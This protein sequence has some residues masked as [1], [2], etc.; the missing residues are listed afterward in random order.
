MREQVHRVQCSLPSEFVVRSVR[1]NHRKECSECGYDGWCEGEYYV[2]NAS[3][4]YGTEKYCLDCAEMEFAENE[5]ED[6]MDGSSEEEEEDDDE[7]LTF[8]VEN[9]PVKDADRSSAGWQ[10]WPKVKRGRYGLV[11][12]VSRQK[13]GY[14]GTAS[15]DT[16]FGK[17]WHTKFKSR[18]QK[19]PDDARTRLAWRLFGF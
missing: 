5:D 2:Y 13:F 4:P 15:E 12:V 16:S 10:L 1:G 17:F 8:P 7:E 14:Y 3:Q 18:Q 6:G 11:F 19:L 9:P